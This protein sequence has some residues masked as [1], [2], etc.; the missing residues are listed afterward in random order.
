MPAGKEIE[1]L[2]SSLEVESSLAAVVVVEKE[3]GRSGKLVE[4]QISPGGH[5]NG[6][7]HSG[8]PTAPMAA[9][10]SQLGSLRRHDIDRRRT[11]V[12]DQQKEASRRVLIARQRVILPRSQPGLGGRVGRDLRR[13]GKAIAWQQRKTW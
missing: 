13:Q 2:T 8:R 10:W 12:H 6:K 9:V 7:T 4:G 11:Q 3:G 1:D 5:R